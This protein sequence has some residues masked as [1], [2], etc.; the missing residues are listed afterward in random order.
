M[1][2]ARLFDRLEQIIALLDQHPMI[3]A[4]FALA[5]LAGWLWK[6]TSEPW[7]GSLQ[8]WEH[9]RESTRYCGLA[10]LFLAVV[11]CSLSALRTTEIQ[12]FKS[13]VTLSMIHVFNETRA[14]SLG[15]CPDDPCY[16]I[17]VGDH[18][19]GADPPYVLVYYGGN[20]MVAKGRAISTPIQ[21]NED[22]W[23]EAVV[24]EATFRFLVEDSRLENL[25]IWIGIV[26]RDISDPVPFV[27]VDS[28]CGIDSLRHRKTKNHEQRIRDQRNRLRELM[29]SM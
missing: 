14:N 22:C 17:S 2:Q 29:K 26:E 7:K 19:V 24:N 10:C 4:A 9:L 23:A 13:G 28:G 27:V 15:N 16:R 3:G 1:V 12:E 8:R 11:W 21:L 5:L 25:K 18:R 20:T 6:R